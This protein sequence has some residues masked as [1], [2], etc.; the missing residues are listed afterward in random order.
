MAK[1]IFGCLNYQI[2]VFPFK[3]V[4]KLKANRIFVY[5]FLGASDKLVKH[6]HTVYMKQ[7]DRK[8]GIVIRTC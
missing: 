8:I 3:K 6:L 4:L 5:K 1:V 2:C 7:S